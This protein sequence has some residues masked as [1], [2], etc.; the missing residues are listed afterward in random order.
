[1]VGAL[2]D[3]YG[4]RFGLTA[5]APVFVVGGLVLASAGAFVEH[6]IAQVWKS[7]A[8]RSEVAHLRQQGKVKLLLARQVDVHYD[9]VQVLFGVDLEVDEGEVVALHGHQ[10]RRQ[11]DPAEGHL[12]AGRRPAVAPSSS[13]GAT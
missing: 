6:D 2:A 11:V 7:T 8:A 3:T 5:A 4:I 12:G 1:M 10:R 9:N 13:T